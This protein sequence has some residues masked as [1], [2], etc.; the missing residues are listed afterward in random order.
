VGKGRCD[1]PEAGDTI[2][3]PDIEVESKDT[4]C[5]AQAIFT[6]DGK[7]FAKSDEQP[8]TATLDPN[9]LPEFADGF[10]HKLE[11]VLVDQN[12]E[13]I[14]QPESVLVA[15]ET[16]K[17]VKVEPSPEPSVGG[18]TVPTGKKGTVSLLDIKD[19]STKLLSLPGLGEL[20]RG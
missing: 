14:P 8:F 17:I 6:V 13:R 18:P 7:E 11:V 5:V 20:Q 4:E 9:S 1:K 3:K 19:M 12:G 16:P 10:D 15:I 2:A